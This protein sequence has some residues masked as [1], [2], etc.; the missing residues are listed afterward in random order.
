MRDL[1][2]QPGFL[3]LWANSALLCIGE[4]LVPSSLVELVS[5]GFALCASFTGVSVLLL[6][7]HL[8]F[9]LLLLL[10]IRLRAMSVWNAIT[11]FPSFLG[12]GS[13]VASRTYSIE[14]LHTAKPMK[15]EIT[16][17]GH[18]LVLIDRYKVIRKSSLS[19]PPH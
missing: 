4:W 2:V 19:T 3:H 15:C 16:L 17:T 18:F 13:A 14:L 10:A 8:L 9:G 12:R 1:E 6:G 5:I 7:R 11:P